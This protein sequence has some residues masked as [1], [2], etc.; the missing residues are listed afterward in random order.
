LRRER[1]DHAVL[2]NLGL[3]GKLAS[4][5]EKSGRGGCTRGK[6]IYSGVLQEKFGAM[7]K[8]GVIK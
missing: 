2:I 6:L 3:R 1:G 8:D 5:I 7:T 4:G